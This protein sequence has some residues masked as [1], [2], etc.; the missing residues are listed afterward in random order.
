MNK[1]TKSIIT[2]VIL[3]FTGMPV[4]A[5]NLSDILGGLGEALGGNGQS[6]QN[7]T[8]QNNNGGSST[9][10]NILEGV[11]SSSNITVSNMAGVWT[12]NGPAVCFQSDNF[13]QKAGGIA[14]A[15]MIESKLSPYYNQYGLNGAVMTINTDGTFSMKLKNITLKGNITQTTEKGVFQ[16]TFTALGSVKLGSIKT[17]I[18]KSYNTLSVM[19]DASKLKNLISGIAKIV[20]I[21]IVKTLTSI[22]DSYQGLCVGFRMERTGNVKGQSTVNGS[23][24]D[25]GSSSGL[26]G[27]INVLGGNRGTDSTSNTKAGATANKSGNTNTNKGSGNQSGSGLGTLIDILSKG[28]K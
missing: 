10:G 1:L 14:A 28:K 16:F 4:C 20:N 17:Y 7:Q 11:F 13:L 3:A 24:S 23:D 5:Q 21:Q 2:A 9:L 8:G 27:L 26:G 25:N 12:S 22:L 18:Q 19:F 15:S 6:S